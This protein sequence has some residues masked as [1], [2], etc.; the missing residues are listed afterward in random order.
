MNDWCVG[1]HDVFKKQAEANGAEIVAEESFKP[2]ARDLRSQLTKIKA[3]KPDALYFPS[4]TEGALVGFKQMKELGVKTLVLG[5]DGWDDTKIPN[6]G[7]KSVEGGQYTIAAS[8]NLPD[9][10]TSEMKK[11]NADKGLNTYSPRVYDIVNVLAGI[12][13]RVGTDG[14]KIKNELY[15]VKVYQGIADE[16]S[17]DKNGDVETAKFIIKEFKG[18]KAV[19]M[20]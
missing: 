1:L 17:L 8:R 5:G 9:S 19:E 14:T 10:F 11:R 13:G 20:K 3:A 7:G 12:M 16:Y 2:D 4:M 15:A 6:E 18:G